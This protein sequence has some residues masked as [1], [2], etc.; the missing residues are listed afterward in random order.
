MQTARYSSRLRDDGSISLPPQTRRK[1]RLRAGDKVEVVIAPT[2]G[3][4]GSRQH[5]IRMS[6]AKERRMNTLLLRNREGVIS[7]EE[8]RE[9]KALV[10]EDQL[11]TL[12]KANRMLQRLRRKN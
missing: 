7:P 10:L 12:E 6:Q 11:L 8:R 3:K 4:T 5:E 1:L 2:N 9:M